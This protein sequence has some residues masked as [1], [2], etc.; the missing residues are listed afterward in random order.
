VKQ[1][2]VK[3]LRLALQIDYQQGPNTLQSSSR[4]QCPD[5]E[6]GEFAGEEGNKE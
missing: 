2:V 1:Y 6:D 5:F 4:T 3:K